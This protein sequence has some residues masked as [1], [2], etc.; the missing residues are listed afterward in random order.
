MPPLTSELPQCKRCIIWPPCPRANLGISVCLSFVGPSAVILDLSSREEVRGTKDSLVYTQE[1]KH[2]L[3]TEFRLHLRYT[4]G[5]SAGSHPQS[6]HPLSW[7]SSLFDFSAKP[8]QSGT[9]DSCLSTSIYRK[10]RYFVNK[11]CHGPPMK[12]SQWDYMEIFSLSISIKLFE[13]KTQLK[14]TDS[15]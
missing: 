1:A 15:S 9:G 7:P 11:F 12:T 13:Q 8:R 2:P 6:C 5:L 3:I 10:S 14:P 4:A